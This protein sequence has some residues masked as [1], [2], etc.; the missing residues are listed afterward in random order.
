MITFY[1]ILS[2]LILLALCMA[3]S[4]IIK[5]QTVYRNTMDVA[6]PECGQPYVL[7]GNFDSDM[8]M[9]CICGCSFKPSEPIVPT[10]LSE[11]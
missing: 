4:I 3:Y 6:C 7:H 9:Q 5:K 2:I 1:I 11:D 10:T 8:T